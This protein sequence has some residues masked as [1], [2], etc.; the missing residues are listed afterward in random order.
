MIDGECHGQENEEFA[1]EFENEQKET[2]QYRVLGTQWRGQEKMPVSQM[3]QSM[4]EAGRD[5]KQRHM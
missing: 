3:G 2:R 4:A 5:W 1:Q